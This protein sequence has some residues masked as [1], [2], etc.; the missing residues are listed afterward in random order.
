MTNQQ[1][2]DKHTVH[3]KCIVDGC[4]NI[5]IKFNIRMLKFEE[6]GFIILGFRKLRNGGWNVKYSD[7]ERMFYYYIDIIILNID[8]TFCIVF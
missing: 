3:K 7:G 1:N 5:N 8:F 2:C 6:S 4:N